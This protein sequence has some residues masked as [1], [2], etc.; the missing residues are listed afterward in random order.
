VRGEVQFDL[1]AGQGI[2][3]AVGGGEFVRGEVQAAL[4]PSAMPRR[5]LEVM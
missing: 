3:K 1:G 5:A 4:E 2:A